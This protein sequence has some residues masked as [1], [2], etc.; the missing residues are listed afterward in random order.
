MV[1]RCGMVVC[2]DARCGCG[3]PSDVEWFDATVDMLVENAVSVEYV[4]VWNV[5]C[6]DSV[7][8]NLY[9]NVM[10]MAWCEV[11]CGRDEEW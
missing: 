8:R 11:E 3:I 5:C 4:V 10:C 6:G 7:M 9:L 2:C 1:M